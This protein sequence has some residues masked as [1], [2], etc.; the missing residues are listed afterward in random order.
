M[1]NIKLFVGATLL[2][3]VVLFGITVAVIPLV[4]SSDWAKDILVSKV[5]TSSP[6]TLALGDCAIGWTKGLQCSD[7]SYQDQDYQ[8][9]AAQL[10]G[11]QGMFALLMAPR[12][13]GT[14]TVDDPLVII[15]QPQDNIKDDI[16]KEGEGAEGIAATSTPTT[17]T[18]DAEPPAAT[19]NSKEQDPSGTWFWHKMSGKIVLN[20]AVVQLQQGEQQPQSVLHDGALDLSLDADV[21]NL[22]LSLVTDDDQTAAQSAEQTTGQLKAV[23]T[24][25][26][27]SEKGNLLDRITAD[28]QITLTDIQ[29]APLLALIPD[30]TTV[31]QGQAVLNSDLTIQNT[32]GGNVVLRGPI[33]LTQVD[34]TGGF[35]QE[36]H[37]RLDQL[38]FELHLQRDEQ[39]EWRL[40]ELKMLSDI[41]SLDLQSTYGKQ[42]LQAAGKGTFDLPILLTQLPGLLKAQ[43]NLRL[44]DGQA[45]LA[46]ELAEKDKTIHL[47][48]DATVKDLAGRQNKQSFV[49]KSPLTLS[50]N[51]SMID[52]KPE[53]EQLALKA[54]FLN[55]EGQGNLQHFSLKGSA[56]LDK[57]M[58][59]ISRIIQLDWDA[60]GRLKLDLETTKKEDRYT[61]QAQVDIADYQLSLNNKKVLP[62]HDLHLNSQLI[63]PGY[64][65]KTR[66]EAADL[67][68]DVSCWAGKFNGSLTGVYQDQEQI[69]AHY[70]LTSDFPLARVTELL[71]RFDA[72][73]QETSVA[74]EMKFRTSGYTEKDRLVVSSLDSRIKDFILYRQKK[75]LQD[76][77]IALFTTKPEPTPTME[78]AVRP[79]EQADSKDTFFAQGGGY[80]LIDTKNHRLVLRN[81]SLNSGFADIRVDK[82]FLD[83][84]QQK[85][86]P[87][88]KALQVSGRSDLKKVTTLLQQLGIM[89][90]EQKFA[91]DAIFSLDL[92]EKKQ[93][94]KVAG[95]TGRGNAGT[96]KLDIDAFTYSKIKKD[97]RRRAKEERLIERQKLVFRSRLHGDLMTGDVQ[98]TTFD[99]ESAPLSLEAGGDLQ[100]SGKKP[101]FSLNGQATPDLAS[102]VAIIEG[103]YP[104]DMKLKG[105]KKENF[106]LYYPLSAANEKEKENA[107]INLRF[108]TKV[109]ADYFSKSGVDMSRLTLDSNMKKG[110]ITNHLK[111]VLNDGWVRLSPRIDYRKNPPLLTIPPGEQ[112]LTDVH[113]EQALTDGLLKGIHPLFGSLARPAGNINVRLDHFSLP[114]GEKGIEKIN[115]KVFFDLTGVALQSKGVLK[116]I[117]DIAGYVDQRLAMKNK[118]MTCQGVQGQISCSPIKITIADSEMRLSGSV[119]MDGRLDYVLDVPVTKRLLGKKGY[120][121]LKGTTLKVPIRGTKDKPVY[122]RR[123]LMQASSDL[124]KQAARQATK[125]VLRE[126]VDKVMPELM[127]NKVVPEILNN[128]VVPDL[129]NNLFGN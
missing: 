13:L 115:F 125:N 23:G 22:N 30:K 73:E 107:K 129:L 121:L 3:T 74:G 40:P 126:Q 41:G 50:V 25:Q 51:G 11:S 59:E 43:E 70:Q 15:R 48:A 37:P 124:L 46:F 52:K 85:P 111:G 56:D 54:D 39:G 91:G 81:L 94:I 4:L 21:L 58:Q 100:L 53:I 79:L 66:A 2:F 20:R 119:G 97:R 32:E 67:T 47:Q 80:N 18:Q 84:W 83:N 12:N 8:V 69:M 9:N 102:L 64:F 95:T 86:A 55:I 68:F 17:T 14:I 62:T 44:E 82:I 113:L 98:F 99:I 108:A 105:K 34:L 36:D 122:S 1:K 5:N 33:T 96:V 49:W 78:E 28:M 90:P 10:S 109:S 118:S 61:V 71:H 19:E 110:V 128:K 35:L 106:T 88:I 117:L 87:A 45:T 120:E 7:I 93:G 63:A 31:P 77:H 16:S 24:A 123:A 112:V 127:D 26:L 65:P 38:A 92:I 89:P 42:G 104:L 60:R 114:L 103:I 76:P 57:A 29:L 101:H 72:L 75:V 116:S 6:G 27:P